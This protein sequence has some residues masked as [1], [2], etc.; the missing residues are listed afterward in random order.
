MCNHSGRGHILC[1]VSVP[2][3]LPRESGTETSTHSSCKVN[4]FWFH[5]AVI[6]KLD[7]RLKLLRQAAEHMK[8]CTVILIKCTANG[9]YVANNWTHIE[10][11]LHDDGK[12]TMERVA[13]PT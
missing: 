11:K 13:L 10:F 1:I 6:A 8:N 12:A 3:F 5:A 9:C 4:H 7:Y 2:E